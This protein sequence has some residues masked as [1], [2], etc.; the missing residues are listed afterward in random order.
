M[1]LTID[2]VLG[3]EHA[4]VEIE[5]CKVVEV[6][7]PNAS[8]KTSLAVCAQAVLAR[9]SNPLG[10][11]A[12]EAKRA[13]GHHGD[14]DGKVELGGDK[15]TIWYVSSG[16]LLTGHHAA[17]SR[18]EAVGLIDFT[19]RRGAKERAQVFQSVLLPP[20]HEV[21][22]ALRER[23]SQYMPDEDLNGVMKALTE[24]GWEAVE[25]IYA[26]RGRESKRQWREVTGKTYGVRVASDWRPD[27]WLADYDH[28]TVQQAE[29][30]VIESRDALAALHKVQAVSEV[31]LE[32]AEQ[33]RGV[34]PRMK[35]R[36][37]GIDE[38]LAQLRADAPPVMATQQEVMRVQGNIHNARNSIADRHAC[39]HCG[40][41]LAIMDGH[42][43][44][45]DTDTSNVTDSIKS[46]ESELAPLKDKLAQ[47]RIEM[48]NVQMQLDDAG[49]RRANVVTDLRIYE[50]DA[51]KTGEVETAERRAALAEAEQ[52]VENSRD[53]LKMVKAEWD[54]AQLHET[55][56]RYTEIARAVGPQ[57]VRAKML[58]SGLAKLN[59]GLAVLSKEAHWPTV[60]VAENGSV[61]IDDRPSAL[62]SES[63]RWRAQASVQLTLAALSG[64]QVVVLDRT[65][66]LDT[67]A[68][69]GLKRALARVIGKTNIAI[70]LCGTWR[71][72]GTSH[73]TTP[74]WNVYTIENGRMG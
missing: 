16:K 4:E 50:R 37:A 25:A 22:E 2:N 30:S 41:S 57:G 70:L 19:A 51:A 11:G 45:A 72:D 26:E 55:I 73:Q 21:G 17:L 66:L 42:I 1:K 27:G 20:A 65:D 69:D 64:S 59:A 60:L 49:L 54:A 29:E 39:P 46:W 56:V 52:H 12:A 5:P 38:E 67:R 53:T 7:G 33:A 62:C 23:L 18:P 32:K 58:E 24:R 28:M 48:T 47:Q 13:Y 40:G 3:I 31:E 63:E 61:S 71:H 43:R 74:M 44:V 35:E 36:L 15:E 14:K 68:R 34:I 6:V 8:G 9:D 10:L